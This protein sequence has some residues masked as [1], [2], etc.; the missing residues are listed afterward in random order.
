MMM[1]VHLCCFILLDLH[2]NVSCSSVFGLVVSFCASSLLTWV[3]AVFYFFKC[4][5]I[6]F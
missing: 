1:G 6:A 3:S 5:G 2:A 4:E